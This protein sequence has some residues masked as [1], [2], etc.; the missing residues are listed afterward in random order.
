MKDMQA[1]D[2]AHRIGQKKTVEVFRLITAG[3]IEE[4]LIS[5]Q[6][7]KKYI[8]NN[9]VDQ[10]KIHECNVNVNNFMESLEEFSADKTQ[11]KKKT[12]P[13]ITSGIKTRRNSS[14]MK[15]SVNTKEWEKE[16]LDEE[17]QMQYLK[18]FI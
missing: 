9:V 17:K 12:A 11:I 6:T 2:R 5:L 14:T 13:T 3:S 16:D 1:M 8:A 10:T 18:Q 7:F 4:K 15:N